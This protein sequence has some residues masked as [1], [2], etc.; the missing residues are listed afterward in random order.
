MKNPTQKFGEILQAL[1]RVFN[2]N[3]T[4]RAETLIETVISVFILSLLLWPTASMLVDAVRA[5][6]TDRN[7]LIAAALADEG[8]E[9]I[10]NFRDTNFLKF[11]PKAEQCWDA[12]PDTAIDL[13]HCDTRENRLADGD[14]RLSMNLD[15]FEWQLESM[16]APLSDTLSAPTDAQYRLKLDP[17]E[18]LYNYASGD[19]TSFYRSVSISRLPNSGDKILKVVS[20]VVYR[21]SGSPR[22]LKRVAFLTP[23]AE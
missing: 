22:K 12:K 8:I 21:Q 6:A 19:D 9:M 23:Y 11:S 14:F 10:T 16:A 18:H 17:A 13:E 3:K 15:S 5:T 1:K 4:A 2:R 20:K 7:D